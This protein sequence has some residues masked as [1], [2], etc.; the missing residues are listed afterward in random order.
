MSHISEQFCAPL[1]R[2]PPA[3]RGQQGLSLRHCFTRCHQF[4]C[5][6]FY[7]ISKFNRTERDMSMEDFRHENIY[8]QI[9]LENEKRDHMERL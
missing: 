3:V 6:G 4:I 9:L 2:R 5:Q 8:L 1:K 7:L